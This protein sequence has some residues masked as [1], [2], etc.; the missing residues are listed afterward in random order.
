MKV[1][2]TILYAQTDIY[3]VLSWAP[4]AS[5]FGFTAFADNASFANLKNVW[6]TAYLFNVIIDL[7]FL[8]RFV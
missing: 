8:L 5:I 4:Q 3:F 1:F 6:I 7:I 2:E